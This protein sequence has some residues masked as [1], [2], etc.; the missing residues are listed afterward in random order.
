MLGRCHPGERKRTTAAKVKTVAQD[1]G[2]GWGAAQLRHAAGVRMVTQTLFLWGLKNV[3]G[4]R[5]GAKCSPPAK[6]IQEMSAKFADEQAAQ[7]LAFCHAI[8]THV[9]RCAR[10]R[11]VRDGPRAAYSGSSVV[12]DGAIVAGKCARHD[13]DASTL[14]K[15]E[16]I[17][18]TGTKA[19]WKASQGSSLAVPTAWQEKER[20]R[21]DVSITCQANQRRVSYTFWPSSI[22]AMDC[23]VTVQES[24]MQLTLPAVLSLIVQVMT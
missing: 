3:H 13:L 5:I 24:Q 12:S 23:Y 10:H 8:R 18:Q 4:V 9:L 15:T 7:N 22:G 20:G 19:I 6:A 2:A 16:R 17:A 1:E 14:Q 11:T 21:A